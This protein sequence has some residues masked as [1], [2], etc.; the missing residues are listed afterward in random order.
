MQ[1]LIVEDEPATRNA[2]DVLIRHLG[3]GVCWAGSR[4][5]AIHLLDTEK[6]DL[7]LL[8][9]TADPGGWDIVRYKQLRP[10]TRSI[11]VIVLADAPQALG[12]RK[13]VL[14][15][16]AVVLW[17]PVEAV[18]LESALRAVG[19]GVEAADRAAACF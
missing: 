5:A 12:L 9:L 16:A 17:K 4:E 14:E 3:Y 8:D 7:I 19:E 2:L 1:V 15:S 18:L 6:V 11:P 13:R 10:E